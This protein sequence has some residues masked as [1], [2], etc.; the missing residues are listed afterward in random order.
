M[1]SPARSPF[2]SATKVG[3]PAAEKP[4]DQALQGDGLAGAGRAGDQPV[5]V[6]ALELELLRLAAAGCR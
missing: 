4:F 5:A 3:T 6:G 1:A 2:T